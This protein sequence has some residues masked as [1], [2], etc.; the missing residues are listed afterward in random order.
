MQSKEERLV[1]ML[2]NIVNNTIAM[3]LEKTVKSEMKQ[4]VVP[5]MDRTMS[6]YFE[7]IEKQVAQV[8]DN[9]CTGIKCS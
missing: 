3:K 8:Y 2:S 1:Q 4:S 5:A 6:N 7:N 9:V